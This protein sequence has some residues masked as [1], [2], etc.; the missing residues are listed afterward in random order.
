[1]SSEK[2]R[3]SRPVF[4]PAKTHQALRILR[5]TSC[6]K[7]VVGEVF[8]VLSRTGNP[9]IRLSVRRAPRHSELAIQRHLHLWATGN[10]PRPPRKKR[11]GNLVNRRG[12]K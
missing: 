12:L 2:A 9:Y 11:R 3:R 10:Q 7:V 1:M 5:I 4:A 8:L 6:W